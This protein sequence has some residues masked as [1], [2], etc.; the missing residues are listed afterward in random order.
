[1]RGHT[2]DL[3]ITNSETDVLSLRIGGMISDHA[4]ICFVLPLKK[5][6][7]K[8]QWVNCR[9]WR[10]LSRDAFASDLEESELCCCYDFSVSSAC[11]ARRSSGSVHICQPGQDF[12]RCVRRCDVVHPGR[13]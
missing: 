6:P 13:D 2:L 11:V 1:M 3:V 12:P 5:L 4:L 8:A 10:R 7:V 9:A